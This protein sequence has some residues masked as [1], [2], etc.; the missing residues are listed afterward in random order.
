MLNANLADP[1]PAPDCPPGG[2][3]A[4]SLP[5]S[6]VELSVDKSYESVTVAPQFSSVT[7]GPSYS[8]YTAAPSISY[9]KS[10]GYA[11]ADKSPA[12]I[13]ASIV[14]SG[15]IIESSYTLLAE[16]L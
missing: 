3:V 2:H 4:Y 13:H 7:V 11:Y 8:S 12:S 10:L 15:K 14:P 1:A 6:S 5:A 9:A 16:Q